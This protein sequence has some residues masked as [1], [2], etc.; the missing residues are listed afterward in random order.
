MFIID[1]QLQYLHFIFFAGKAETGRCRALLERAMR[2]AEQVAP[3]PQE[4]H[5]MFSEVSYL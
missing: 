5:D 1:S 2:A 4:L 3:N